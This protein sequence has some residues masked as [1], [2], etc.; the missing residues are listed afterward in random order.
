V[1]RNPSTLASPA[2]AADGSL[3]RGFQG[4]HFVIHG[5]R[6]RLAESERSALTRIRT[7]PVT[8]TDA[9]EAQEMVILASHLLRIVEARR[10]T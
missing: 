2:A 6:K 10:P 5:L 8:I 3:Q 4:G 7:R 9:S 1:N